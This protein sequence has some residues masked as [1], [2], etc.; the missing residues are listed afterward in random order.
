MPA[1]QRQGGLEIVPGDAVRAHGVRFQ[2][3][4]APRQ[5]GGVENRLEHRV[6]GLAGG[7][8]LKQGDVEE[9]VDAAIAVEREARPGDGVEGR[10]GHVLDFRPGAVASCEG[11]LPH[12]PVRVAPVRA[13]RWD[14]GRR[15]LRPSGKVM[16]NSSFPDRVS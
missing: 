15:S 13:R 4:D 11:S 5:L 6:E 8:R 12:R 1:L 9:V 7:G 10:R 16:S 2:P 14:I 3:Q